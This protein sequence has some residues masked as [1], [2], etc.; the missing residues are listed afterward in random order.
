[1]TVNR[2]FCFDAL[3][4]PRNLG[5]VCRAL[6]KSSG[7]PQIR[8]TGWSTPFNAV[9]LMTPAAGAVVGV[10]S[11]PLPRV[12]QKC[13]EGGYEPVGGHGQSEQGDEA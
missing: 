5:L 3:L 7:T 10:F 8:A 13:P 4:R 12:T 9:R 6:D 11:C 1:M 2:P